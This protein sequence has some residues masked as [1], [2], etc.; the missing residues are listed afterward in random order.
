MLFLV[1][2]GVRRKASRA[3]VG[4]L[5]CGNAILGQSSDTVTR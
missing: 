2:G 4:W 5:G 1:R 3:F